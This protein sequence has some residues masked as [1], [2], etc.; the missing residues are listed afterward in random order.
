MPKT[1]E[2]QEINQREEKNIKRKEQQPEGR[3]AQSRPRYDIHSQRQTKCALDDGR[4]MRGRELAS[5]CYGN[6]GGIRETT[7]NQKV[8]WAKCVRFVSFFRLSSILRYFSDFFPPFSQNKV[9]SHSSGWGLER[10]E[11]GK[12]GLLG[13][14]QAQI[15]QI[16]SIDGRGYGNIPRMSPNN[17][18]QPC[19][20]DIEIYHI[21]RDFSHL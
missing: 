13:K 6:S 19:P 7:K 21:S 1:G 14:E 9:I 10:N 8:L 17:T 5:V 20:R 12:E 18:P 2:R 16:K 4:T 15:K 3:Y 11:E